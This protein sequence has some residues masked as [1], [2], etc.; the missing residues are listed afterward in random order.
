MVV[1]FRVMTEA[2]IRRE[3]LYAMS[4]RLEMSG[5]LGPPDQLPERDISADALEID[6]HTDPGR[7]YSGA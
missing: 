3:L 6:Q 1:H 5:I 2:V 4:Q 7:G